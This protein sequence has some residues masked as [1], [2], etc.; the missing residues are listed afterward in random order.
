MN[1]THVA[2]A[3]ES[4]D[5]LTSSGGDPG[6]CTASCVSPPCVLGKPFPGHGAEF[7]GGEPRRITAFW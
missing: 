7:G 6:L 4:N 5:W 3:S 2:W 1:G